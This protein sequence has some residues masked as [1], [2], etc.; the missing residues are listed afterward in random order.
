MIYIV[1]ILVLI[2]IIHLQRILLE[3]EQDVFQYD[4]C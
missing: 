2:I 3:S 4:R 1:R